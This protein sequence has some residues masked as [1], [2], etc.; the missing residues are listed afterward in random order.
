MLTTSS[1]PPVF[2]TK[3]LSGIACGPVNLSMKDSSCFV[4]LQVPRS[5][6]CSLPVKSGRRGFQMGGG[7]G[8]S[9]LASCSGM[10]CPV[11]PGNAAASASAMFCATACSPWPPDAFSGGE[12]QTGAQAGAAI[13]G[14]G[15]DEGRFQGGTTVGHGAPVFMI[16]SGTFDCTGEARGRPGATHWPWVGVQAGGAGLATTF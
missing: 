11:L 9:S 7:S 16:G 1:S 4:C 13:V 2:S 6:F 15:V 10:A 14:A 5:N 12:T 8:T 3:Y